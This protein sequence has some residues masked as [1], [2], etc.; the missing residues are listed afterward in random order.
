M[1]VAIVIWLLPPGLIKPK[2]GESAPGVVSD[3]ASAPVM[4]PAGPAA[5]EAIPEIEAPAAGPAALAPAAPV[6]AAPTA[7]AEAAGGA[8]VLRTTAQ[9]WVKS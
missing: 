2:G 7:P 1:G 8:I 3:V 9:S 6:A 4:P 5:S